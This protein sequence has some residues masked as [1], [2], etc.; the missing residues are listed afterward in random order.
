MASW[1]SVSMVMILLFMSLMMG[2]YKSDARQLEETKVAEDG[3]STKTIKSP[4]FILAT[5]YAAEDEDDIPVDP[6]GF[7]KQ[8]FPPV[9]GFKN[10]YFSLGHAQRPYGVAQ[11]PEEFKSPNYGSFYLYPRPRTF[12]GSFYSYPR[13]LYAGDSIHR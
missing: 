9:F 11:T 4:P 10:R 5:N 12:Y 6:N 13:T 1:R 3:L 7:E 8:I 2:A